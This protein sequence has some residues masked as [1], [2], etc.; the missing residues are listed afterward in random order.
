VNGHVRATVKN[1]SLHFDGEHSLSRNLA[2]C[3]VGVAITMGIDKDQFRIPSLTPT[4][5][6][7]RGGLSHCEG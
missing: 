1:R 7:N 2:E 5:V 4:H 6:P 3:D